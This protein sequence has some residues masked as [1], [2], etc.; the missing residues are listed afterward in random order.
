MALGAGGR[1]EMEEIVD[2]LVA[3]HREPGHAPSSRL[4]VQRN[5]VEELA[6]TISPVSTQRWG[7]ATARAVV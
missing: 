5:L 3:I 4:L 1:V 6:R 7:K 2:G